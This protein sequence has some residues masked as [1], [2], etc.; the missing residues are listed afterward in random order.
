MKNT[1]T[2]TG[3]T[4]GGCQKS[5]AEKLNAV[6]QV[7]TTEVNLEEGIATIHSN[8]TISVKTLQEALPK[9]YGVGMLTSKTFNKTKNKIEAPSK[10]NQLRPLFLIFINLI[11]VASLLNMNNWRLDEFMLDFMGLFFVVFSFFKFLDL[12]GFQYSF[13]MYD[14]LS[15]RLKIYG[16]LYPFIELMLGLFFLF[17]FELSIALWLTILILGITTVG[18]IQTLVSKIDIRCACLGTVVKLPMTE[19]TLIENMLMISMAIIML[20]S[21]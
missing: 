3:M 14:P 5:V 7:I 8:Q 16:W 12:K 15:S 6:P 17:R 10:L 18:V 1:Y 20:I 19:A 13:A 4:C 9:K 11:V 21:I 2:I